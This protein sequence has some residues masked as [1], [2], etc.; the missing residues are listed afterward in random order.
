MHYFQGSREHRPPWGDLS[1]I[2]NCILCYQIWD[3]TYHTDMLFIQGESLFKVLKKQQQKLDSNGDQWHTREVG[4]LAR[5]A[6][7]E[8]YK[9]ASYV[10]LFNVMQRLRIKKVRFTFTAQY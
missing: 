8:R 10:A 9:K 6:K 7:R 1:S 2:I 5:V 4:L 3:T